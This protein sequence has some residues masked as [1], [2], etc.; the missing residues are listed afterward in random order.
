MF[1]RAYVLT[2]LSNKTPKSSNLQLL[3]QRQHLL[4][5]YFKTLSTGSA[6]YRT[7]ASRTVDWYLTNQANQTVVN[8][9]LGFNHYV[10]FPQINDNHYDIFNNVRPTCLMKILVF[11]T[12]TLLEC[13]YDQMKDSIHKRIL[14]FIALIQYPDAIHHCCRA[15]QSERLFVSFDG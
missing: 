8:P 14:I 3:E 12:T 11:H 9:K 7:Q 2:L 6:G 10:L 4:P 13:F 1:S 5:N 15:K